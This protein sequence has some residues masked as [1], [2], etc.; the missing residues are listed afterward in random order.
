MPTEMP[1][2][3]VFGAALAE[4]AAEL[5]WSL[6]GE[7]YCHAGGEQFFPSE[8][9]EELT[10]AWLRVAAFLGEALGE[11]HGKS[12]YVGAATAE[13]GP[14]LFESLVLERE[15]RALNLPGPE[16]EELNRA[17]AAVEARLAEPLPRFVT[18]PLAGLDARGF[19]HGWLV[20]VLSDPECF[21]ALSAELYGRGRPDPAP[22]AEDRQAA[23][24]LVDA[25]LARLVPGA[26]IS[27]SEEELELCAAGCARRGLA[28]ELAPRGVLTA[29]VG[30]PLRVGRSVPAD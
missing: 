26:R 5:D 1:G 3:E 22:L 16:L 29:I 13:L 9:V 6:L 21:P 12:L 19:D 11:A 15:V 17:L 28:L 18:T 4:L 27:T 24:A 2:V 10:E 14:L 20:S 23:A 30:D 25:W 7:L 8:Q